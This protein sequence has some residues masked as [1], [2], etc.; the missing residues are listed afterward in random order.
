MSPWVFCIHKVNMKTD[1]KKS[2]LKF[3][4]IEI[5][6][7]Y[8]KAQQRLKEKVLFNN[9]HGTITATEITQTGY[10]TKTS[11]DQSINLCILWEVYHKLY[12]FLRIFMCQGSTQ[13][14]EVTKSLHYHYHYHHHQYHFCYHY[15]VRVPTSFDSYGSLGPPVP[16]S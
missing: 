4:E 10:S 14:A 11:S 9:S 1:S 13:Y 7:L 3:T 15:I 6:S 5:D 16:K 12:C 2:V 8:C